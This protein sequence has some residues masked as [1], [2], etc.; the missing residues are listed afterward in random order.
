MFKSILA[1]CAAIALTAIPFAAFAADGQGNF[2]VRGVGAQTC[3]ALNA[4]L[5]KKDPNTGLVLESW[6]GGYLSSMN[7]LQGDTFDASP[8]LAN[9]VIAQMV[10]NVCQRAPTSTVETVTFDIFRAM[11]PSRVRNVSTN[12]EA[13]VGTA[14]VV[15][16]KETLIAIQT[17][18]QRQGL[19]KE[20]PTGLFTPATEAALKSFQAAHKLPQ[21]GVPDPGTTIAVLAPGK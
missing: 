20:A 14:T 5:A 17:E 10:V 11:A 13:K 6:V 16:R 21:T 2:A 4:S 19:S 15:L 1:G 9:A 3:Q 7:R 8:I 18:L 12:V